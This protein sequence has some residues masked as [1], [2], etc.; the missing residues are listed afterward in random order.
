MYQSADQL[1][2]NKIKYEYFSNKLLKLNKKHK[3]IT[4][5][6]LQFFMLANN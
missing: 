1:R 6:E 3:L 5:F 4:L 2:I